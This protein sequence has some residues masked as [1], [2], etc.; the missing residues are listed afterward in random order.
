MI[1]AAA[2]GGSDWRNRMTSPIDG[3]RAADAC[4]SILGFA[5]GRI[6]G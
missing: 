6:P 2:T 3:V 4:L 5:R 1:N